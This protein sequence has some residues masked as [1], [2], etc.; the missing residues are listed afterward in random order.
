MT[1]YNIE[2]NSF[3]GS[4]Y[5]QLYPKTLLENV[6]NWNSSIYSKSEVDGF[7]SNLNS[8]ISKINTSISN[9]K[10]KCD[11]IT[12]I[13]ISAN[14]EK[15]SFIIPDTINNYFI[16]VLYSAINSGYSSQGLLIYDRSNIDSSSTRPIL[17][18]SGTGL[19][20]IY[21]QDIDI[22]IYSNSSENVAFK[23]SIYSRTYY[24][25]NLGD[26]SST[27]YVYG[28]KLINI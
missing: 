20:G 13:S 21:L 2:M 1:Q 25:R 17:S 11:T 23:N 9:F 7:V 10:M 6:S 28:Y 4:T 3:N 5:D 8:S 16:V 15:S 24:Y 27:L 12:S 19:I 14:T 22:C 18:S 26:D